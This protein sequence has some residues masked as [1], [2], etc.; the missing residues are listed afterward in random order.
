M[1]TVSRTYNCI[2]FCL[3]LGVVLSWGYWLY[4]LLVF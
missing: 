4:D 1:K 3:T 2:L